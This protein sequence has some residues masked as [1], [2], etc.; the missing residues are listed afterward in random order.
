MSNQPTLITHTMK[1]IFLEES[2]YNR[3]LNENADLKLKITSLYFTRL[4]HMIIIRFH[5]TPSYDSSRSYVVVS[6]ALH[7]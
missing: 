1:G 2:E 7:Q 4:F 3:L 6:F 5:L